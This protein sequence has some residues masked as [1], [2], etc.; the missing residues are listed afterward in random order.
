MDEGEPTPTPCVVICHTEGCPRA[1]EARTVNLYANPAP[2][3]YRAS[4]GQCDQPITDITPLV[5]P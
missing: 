4:C 3:I 1:E 2:P 5:A